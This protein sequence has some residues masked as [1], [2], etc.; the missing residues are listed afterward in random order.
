MDLLERRRVLNE[1]TGLLDRSGT[2]SGGVLVV[3]GPKGSGRTALAD[4][5]VEQARRGGLEV[6]RGTPVVGRAGLWVWAQLVRDAGG[7]DELVTRLLAEPG[8]VDLDRA[9]VVLCSG[10]HSL[11]VVDDVDRGGPDAVALLAVLAGRAVAAPVAVLVTSRTPLGIGDEVWLDPLSPA[12]IGAVT[13]ETRPEVRH[14]LWAGSRGLPGRARALAATLDDDAG[15]PVVAL[16]LAAVSD[17]EFLVVDTG[18]IRLLEAAL[19]RVADDRARARLLARL[20]RAL[21]GETGAAARQRALVEESLVLA[22]RCGDQAVLAEVLDARLHALWDPGGADDRLAAAGEIIDLARG[23]ADLERERRG[24]FWRFVALMELGR[25]AE[26]EAVLAAFDREARAAGD[27]A[28]GV[29][30]ASRYAMLAAARG[31]FDDALALIEQVA[32]QGRRVGLAD[33]GRLVATVRGMIVMLREDPSAAEAV[34]GLDELRAL[35][36]RHPGHLY[37]STAARLL[38]ALGRVPEAGLELQRALPAVLAGSGP[39]WLGA[40]ADLCSVAVATGNVP[41]AAQLY[42]ALAGY[43][44]RL[45][46]WAGANTVTGPVSHYLGILAAYLG[47]LDD[48]VELLT[49]AAAWEEDAGALPFLARTLAALGDTLARRGYDGDAGQA[50]DHRRRGHGIAARLGLAGPLASLTPPAGQWTLRRDGPDWLL[51]AGDERA[52]LRDSRGMAYLRALLAAPGREITALDLVAGGAGLAAAAA[53]PVLDAAARDA[54]RRRLAALD[55]VLEAADADGDSGRAQ[56]AA[57]ERDALLDELRRA[58]GLGG[59]NRGMSGADERARVNVTRTLRTALDR[60]ADA[61]P[62]AGAHLTASIRTGRA[63]R[64]Q[65]APGGPRHWSVLPLRTN[66]SL[67]IYASWSNQ[68]LKEEQMSTIQATG[69]PVRIAGLSADDYGRSD[70]RA[71]L[72]LLHGLTFDRTTWRDVIPELQRIDPGCRVVAIDLPG[73]GQSPDQATYDPAALAERLHQAAQDAGLTAPIVAGHSAGGVLATIYAARYPTRGV[74][75]IDQPLETTRFAALLG[76][77]AERLRGP[78]FPAVWQM[79]YDSFHVELLPSAAQDLVRAT[80]RPRQQVVLGY[81]RQLL[82][83]P[84]EAAAMVEQATAALRESGVPYLHVAGG[85]L[86]PDSRQ[87]LGARLPAATVEV[88]PG[89]GHF[90]HLADPQRFARRITSLTRSPAS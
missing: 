61:A 2:G 73:H 63:C 86:G 52:R 85:D 6:L 4:A 69:R 13:G 60:I 80:C 70:D 48:A 58:T 35:A 64:Y 29:M 24:L 74:V 34:S 18:L 87:W 42:S 77:L 44:G 79:F 19:N 36:R 5:A 75:N 11:I 38:V 47:R 66:R 16:A 50:A 40:A 59:R 89:T 65:P 8:D 22:R 90:P 54:Y 46:V 7:S 49:E 62:K 68:Y 1:V 10:P 71:P 56:R 32:E 25:V 88:W 17:E 39:R 31:Q 57:A 30:A 33:T 20:A 3:A 9:A 45:V 84:A 78:E 21:L 41:A 23:S 15:D 82:E 28:A 83:Q 51:T 26:A 14:A 53:E 12:A 67:P 81:W 37:E 76:S 43:R 27:T 72:I 55:D